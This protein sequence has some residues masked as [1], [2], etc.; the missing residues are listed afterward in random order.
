MRRA[1]GVGTS[2]LG[3]GQGDSVGEA[4]LALVEP[5]PGHALDIANVRAHLRDHLA[6]YKVPRRI[7]IAY[8]LPR[9]DSGK[10]FKRRLREPY[11]KDAG[12]K[13]CVFPGRQRLSFSSAAP[14]APPTGAAE[15]PR[16]S[17][18]SPRGIRPL[19]DD[20][21]TN[22]KKEGARGLPGW[23]AGTGPRVAQRRHH[24]RS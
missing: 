5:M 19:P 20:W 15:L 17:A 24:M 3:V 10:I 6:G 23:G 11:W 9:D 4:L 22:L 8:D 7:E 1:R 12:R 18:F 2:A 13:I 16:G 21:L 14:T